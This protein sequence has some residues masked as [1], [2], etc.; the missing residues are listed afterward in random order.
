MEELNKDELW[1][2]GKS[3]L[4]QSGIPK[5][6]C[7]SFVGKL[8]KDFG[9]DVVI[10]AVRAAVVARPADAATY[11]VGAC[12]TAAGQRPKA[13]GKQSALEQHNFDVARRLAAQEA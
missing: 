12:Q 7:G 11:L 5:A 6:Q 2:A 1:A 3:L 9:A 10:G 4:L 8:V 13:L